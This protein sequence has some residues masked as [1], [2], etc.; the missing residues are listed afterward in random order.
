VEGRE[1]QETRDDG[2]D[3]ELEQEQ[4]EDEQKREPQRMG[5]KIPMDEEQEQHP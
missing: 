4:E 5:R 2:G 3:V 1:E